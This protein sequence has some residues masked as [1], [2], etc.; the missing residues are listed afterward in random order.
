MLE[1]RGVG[2]VYP[3]LRGLMRYVV[4]TATD[5]EVVALRGVDLQVASGEVVGLVGPNGAGK[6]TLLKIISTLLL[7]T[8]GCVLV[9]GHD[10]LNDARA[11]R[12]RIGLVLADDRALYWRLT[13]REN[14]EFFGVMHG[15]TR[16]DA[17]ARA[18]VL[19]DQVG[20]A[21]RDKLVFGYSSGMRA[22]LSLARALLT[23]PPLLLLDEP[24]RALDPIASAAVAGMIRDL[25]AEGIAVL[26]SSHRLDEIEQ[27]CDRI[28]V[29][30]DGS[31]RFDGTVSDLSGGGRFA[32]AVRALL[33][34]QPDLPAN[35]VDGTGDGA[36]DVIVDK[37][38]VGPDRGTW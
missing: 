20:L 30:T 35:E 16:R 13:G 24:T 11:V 6:T 15:L 36:A 22:R 29:V 21:S 34:V 5:H 12:D 37:G 18:G 25:A 26:L 38:G 10:P 14:L 32:S 27:A 17:R 1:V 23:R 31:V 9:D 19:L 7:P 33:E 3:R 28:V 8:T 2:M 4:R